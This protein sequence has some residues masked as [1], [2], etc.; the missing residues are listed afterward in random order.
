VNLSLRGGSFKALDDVV[1]RAMVA[2]LHFAI[3][4]KAVTVGALTLANEQAYFLQPWYLCRCFY[5]CDYFPQPI[6]QLQALI[7]SLSGL[8]GVGHCC[9]WHVQVRSSLIGSYV[10]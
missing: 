6:F 9:A 4:E 7:S 2:N 5:H 1:N 3:A 10:T 8:G